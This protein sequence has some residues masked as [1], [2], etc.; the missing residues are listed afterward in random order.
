LCRI[1]QRYRTLRINDNTNVIPQFIF[2]YI[3][4]DVPSRKMRFNYAYQCIIHFKQ[5]KSGLS[6]AFQPAI[7]R[8]IYV[9]NKY[10]AH[11]ISDD[12]FSSL[13]LVTTEIFFS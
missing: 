5:K 10:L 11:D 6:P 9:F 4:K 13:L 8:D 1:V 7:L 2:G 12:F 3:Q